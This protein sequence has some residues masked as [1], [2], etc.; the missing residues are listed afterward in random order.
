MKRIVSILFHS[1]LFIG[2]LLAIDQAF[3]HL[4]LDLPGLRQSQTFYL[5]FRGRLLGLRP[6]S[7]P[8]GP[9]LSVESL[10]EAEERSIAKPKVA[11][12]A[13]TG[14]RVKEPPAPAGAQSPR[15]LYPDA[16][17][18]LQFADR[19]E[20]IPEALRAKAQPLAQ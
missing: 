11:A 13:S 9:G 17:G 4:P 12:P 18:Q 10:I 15:F 7:M 2:L 3:V 6:P 16:S 5:D 8:K 19:L 20:E 1:L 14:P